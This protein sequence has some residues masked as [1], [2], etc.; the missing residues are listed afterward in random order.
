M[1]IDGLPAPQI[2]F[3]GA[4]HHA[5]LQ[6]APY[7]DNLWYG[8]GASYKEGPAYWLVEVSGIPFGITGEILGGKADRNQ[9]R[10]M[11]Y[12][13]SRRLRWGGNEE[14]TALWGL[15]DSFG[16]SNAKWIGYWDPRSPARTD[17]PE[18]PVTVYQRP[19]K[20][21]IVLA[22]WAGKDVSVNLTVEWAAL[23]LDPSKV[24]LRVPK[25][26]LM[27]EAAEYEPEDAL[28]IPHES[29]LILIAE[30]R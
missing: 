21:L 10:G 23:G 17:N 8:E 7:I 27:Q 26:D 24:R 12:G 19:G 13:M 18:V 3:H 30:E 29:G 22:S 16:I 1:T 11:L 20:S 15:W 2:D 5:W 6:H 14:T 4:V 28:P 25:L 9:H